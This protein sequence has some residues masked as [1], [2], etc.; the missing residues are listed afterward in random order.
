MFTVLET[1]SR[2]SAVIALTIT[3]TEILIKNNVEITLVANEKSSDALLILKKVN[4][5]TIT[6]M[7]AP[8]QSIRKNGQFQLMCTVHCKQ[9]LVSY[10]IMS[11]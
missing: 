5:F 11:H 4:A 8:I 2:I 9:Y 1:F 3:I 10:G 7:T 6:G